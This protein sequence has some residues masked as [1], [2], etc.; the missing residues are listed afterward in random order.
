MMVGFFHSSATSV[1][2]W[3]ASQSSSS[4]YGHTAPEYYSSYSCTSGGSVSFPSLGG[5]FSYMFHLTS[6][7]LCLILFIKIMS[8]IVCLVILAGIPA[9]LT[10]LPHLILLAVPLVPLLPIPPVLHW[11]SLCRLCQ[12]ICLLI[13]SSL[14]SLYTASPLNNAL[15]FHLSRL[16]KVRSKPARIPSD[17]RDH[18]YHEFSKF[19]F[20]CHPIPEI[21]II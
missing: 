5:I 4:S 10:H 8:K 15:L 6:L 9:I 12:K 3:G 14:L 1:L 16:L 7:H 13:P 17:Y 2:M 18:S 11:M 21:H 19:C 20:I